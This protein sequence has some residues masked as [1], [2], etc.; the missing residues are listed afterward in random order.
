LGVGLNAIV[1]D[2]DLEEGTIIAGF[3]GQ[4]V[5]LAGKLLAWAALLEGKYVT[6][7]PSYGPEMRGGTA[8]CMIRISANRIGSPYILRPSSLIAMN[9]PSLDRFESVIEAGGCILANSSLI[10][11]KA[12]RRDLVFATV[13]AN[14]IAEKL[15]NVQ[16]ANMVAL[17]AFVGVKPI[18]HIHSLVRALTEVLPA[19]RKDM[20]SINE[21][22]LRRGIE[23]VSLKVSPRSG[24]QF[25]SD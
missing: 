14:M 24:R 1:I 18:L 3:G 6:C 2:G 5:I 11:R 21:E 4:G 19:Q 15:G 20:L 13:Q 16:A 25:S 22:A 17:G 7:M 9:L 12:T 8:N 10:K 23:S